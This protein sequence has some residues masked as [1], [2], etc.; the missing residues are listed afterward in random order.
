MERGG[1]NKNWLGPSP[2]SQTKGEGCSSGNFQ[3]IKKGGGEEK[4]SLQSQTGRRLQ[5]EAWGRVGWYERRWG[6]GL[7][8]WKGIHLWG[9]A[10][11]R[12]EGSDPTTSKSISGREK[13]KFEEK[14][15]G[16]STKNGVKVPQPRFL[17]KLVKRRKKKV[18][19]AGG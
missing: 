5:G 3:T 12:P 1:K 6:S 16:Q 17:M 15:Q 10:R 7:S 9:H 11:G 13:R 18:V 4:T 14:E 8:P 19:V 2:H